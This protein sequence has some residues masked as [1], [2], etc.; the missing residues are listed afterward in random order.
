MKTG[1]LHA[2]F[3]T[4]WWL[5]RPTHSVPKVGPQSPLHGIKGRLVLIARQVYSRITP[6]S[7]PQPW[8]NTAHTLR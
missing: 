1:P 7:S 2:G 4:V 5:P 8:G 6:Q 3:R